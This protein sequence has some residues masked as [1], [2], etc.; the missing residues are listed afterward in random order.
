MKHNWFTKILELID[1]RILQLEKDHERIRKFWAK[2]QQWYQMQE[3][4]DE[5]ELLLEAKYDFISLF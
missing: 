1:L 4:K 2:F 3:I 5:L